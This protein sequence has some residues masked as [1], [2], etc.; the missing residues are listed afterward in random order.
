[1]N[2]VVSTG[3][4]KVILQLQNDRSLFVAC[5]ANQLLVQILNFL[6]SSNMANGSDVVGSSESSL[7]PD[8][9]SVSSEIMNAVVEALSSEDHPQVLQ[10]LRLLSLVLSQC[11]EPIRSTLW[12]DVL[13]PLEVLVN[14][15]SESLIQTLITVLEA[16]VR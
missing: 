2:A 7:R 10:G 3:L 6:T 15:G 9:V 4:I 5:M 8:C 14:R 16:A 13:V 1:M 12:K 11:G